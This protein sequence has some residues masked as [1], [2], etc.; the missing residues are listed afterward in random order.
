MEMKNW[1][2]FQPFHCMCGRCFCGS[3]SSILG[4]IGDNEIRCGN[5]ARQW[6]RSHGVIFSSL[7][8][9]N[10]NSMD[11]AD[12][13]CSTMD[14][15]VAQ[16]AT[17]CALITGYVCCTIQAEIHSLAKVYFVSKSLINERKRR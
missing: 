7:E 5:L 3:E 17:N 15:P 8:N 12:I 2:G 9:R 14:F 1:W 11:P 16:E 13:Q 6:S 10:T 4:G